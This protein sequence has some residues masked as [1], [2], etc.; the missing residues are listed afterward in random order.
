MA[1]NKEYLIQ[2]QETGSILI[3]E[4]VICTI[5]AAAVME[6]EGVESLNANIGTDLAE[7]L[8]MKLLGKGIKL[9]VEENHVTIACSV[10]L[11]YGYDVME[12][13]KNVQQSITNA[14]ES[15]TGFHVQRVDVDVSGVTMPK[16]K[17]AE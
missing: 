12:A 8:G 10:V 9:V 2:E 7:I 1:D 11:S 14:V 5:A 6:V 16:K 17:K 3:S 15:M 13:A 4:E